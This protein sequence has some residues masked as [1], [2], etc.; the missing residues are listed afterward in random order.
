MVEAIQ[1]GLQ[2]MTMVFEWLLSNLY[3]AFII[4][5]SLIM[6]VVGVIISKST[7]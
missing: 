6:L 3:T 7:G 1:L 4:G 5:L 2:V